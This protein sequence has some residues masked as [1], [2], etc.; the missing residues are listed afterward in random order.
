MMMHM[1]ILAAILMLAISGPCLAA[2]HGIKESVYQR[3]WCATQGGIIEYRLPDK[4]RVD[5]VT[6]EYAVEFDFARKWAE[7]IGQALYYGLMTGKRPGLVLIL[8]RRDEQR[9]VDRAREVCDRYGIT[10]WVVCHPRL[11]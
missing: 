9:F 4:A 8:E 10:L 2:G 11:R 7:G 6:D 3:E 5:C 1:R